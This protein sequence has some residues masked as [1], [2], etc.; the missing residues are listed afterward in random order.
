MDDRGDETG[1]A[2]RPRA[3]TYRGLPL[4][5]STADLERE[6]GFRAQDRLFVADRVV[7]AVVRRAVERSGLVAEVSRVRL[8]IEPGPGGERCA[9][10]AVEVTAPYGVPLEALADRLRPVLLDA[11]A[12]TLGP[13]ERTADVHVGDVAHPDDDVAR[14][15]GDQG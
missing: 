1:R 9:G 4:V 3:A 10:V 5:A 7:V 8:R 11:L 14:P 2:G 6:G 12:D 13:A 15:G